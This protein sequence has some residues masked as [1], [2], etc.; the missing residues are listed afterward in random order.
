VNRLAVPSGKGILEGSEN[1]RNSHSKKRMQTTQGSERR[2]SRTR[3]AGKD[4]GQDEQH[5]GRIIEMTVGKRPYCFVMCV[6]NDLG[7]ASEKNG[8]R[9]LG[10]QQRVFIRMPAMRYRKKGPCLEGQEFEISSK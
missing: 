1:N 9:P 5:R 7:N 2:N 3:K 10:G 6:A 4:K 8:E